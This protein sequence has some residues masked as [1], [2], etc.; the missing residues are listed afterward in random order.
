VSAIGSA[1]SPAAVSSPSA[2]VSLSVPSFS[3]RMASRQAI[4]HSP[5]VPTRGNVLP[6]SI[7]PSTPLAER[8][9]TEA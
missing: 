6:I 4:F 8:S 1:G 2:V 9:S 3:A 5:S 7:V